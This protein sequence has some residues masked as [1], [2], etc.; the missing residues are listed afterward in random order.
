MQLVISD[1]STLIHLAA[2]NRFDLIR[3][4]YPSIILPRSVYQEVVTCGTQKPGCEEVLQGVK[5]GEISLRDVQNTR[6]VSSLCHEIHRGEAEVIA[7]GVECDDAFLLLDDHDAR[8]IADRFGLRYTGIIGIFIRA[9]RDGNIS[10]LRRE[11]ER[12]RTDG[13][14]WISELTLQR[15]LQVV[16]EE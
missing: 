3:T 10:S 1:S 15:A 9:R 5:N 4:Y 14:F 7:L 6:L 2:V 13:R 16:G 8:H 11:L 12:L